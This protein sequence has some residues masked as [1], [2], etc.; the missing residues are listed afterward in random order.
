MDVHCLLEEPALMH[1]WGLIYSGCSA[2]G[3]DLQRWVP[4]DGEEAH[5][6]HL[7]DDSATWDQFAVNKEKFGVETTFQEEIYTTRL[8]RNN[9]GISEAEAAKLAREIELGLASN[10]ATN[11]HLLEERGMEVDDNGVS[12]DFNYRDS[13]WHGIVHRV[14]PA[15]MQHACMLPCC[16]SCLVLCAHV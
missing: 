10:P 7:E 5:E 15:A 9:C 14:L 12:Q 16:A 13:C 4:E 2:F 8:D 1:I 11:Y 3:R 6:F